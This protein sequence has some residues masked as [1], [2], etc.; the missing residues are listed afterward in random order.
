MAFK[1]YIDSFLTD[2]PVNDTDLKTLIKR[3]TDIGNVLISQEVEIVYNGDNDLQPG[4]ISGYSYLKNIY[5]NNICQEISFKIVDQVSQ[6]ETIELYI[7]TIKVPNIS[8]DLQR[9]LL[10]TKIQDNSY[11]AYINNNRTVK[12]NLASVKTKS[13]E[14]LTAIQPYRMEMFSTFGCV[15]YGPS[16]G[17]T[18]FKGYKVLD[19]FDFIIRTI[20]DNRIT[21]T[22]DYF[23]EIENQ[24]FMLKG[25]ALINPYTQ[26]PLAPEPVIEVSFEELFN[27]MS[28]QYNL[29]FWI[30]DSDKNDIK[31]KIENS[32]RSFSTTVVHQMN[33]LFDL[34]SSIFA[35]QTYGVVKVGSKIFDLTPSNQHI[36]ETT[37]FG[38]KEESYFPNGQCNVA[39]ELNLVN[40]FVIDSNII[41]NLI[42]GSTSEIDSICLIECEQVD[43]VLF[44]TRA[45]IFYPFNNS[46]CCYN[47]GLNNFNKLQRNSGRFSDLLSNLL[48]TGSNTYLVNMGYDSS[49]NR[50]YHGGGSA[51][52]PGFIPIGGQTYDAD[53]ENETT[54]GGYDFD[55]NY[56][57]V[58]TFEYTAPF[59][60]N[61]SFFHRMFFSIAGIQSF[62]NF[63]VSVGFQHLDVGSVFI[64]QQLGGGTYG[65]NGS[66]SQ[67]TTYVV[68]ALAGEKIRG[69]YRFVYNPNGTGNQQIARNLV[70]GYTSFHVCTGVPDEGLVIGGSDMLSNKF[71]YDFFHDI[72]QTDFQAIK[73]NPTG[74]ITFE[75][76]GVTRVGW[77]ESMNRNDWTGQTQIRLITYQDAIIRQ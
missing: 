39:T 22:S 35:D 55:G 74:A 10:K 38:W 36:P 68:A 1:F 72:N 62:E 75:K 9:T 5:D 64:A 63:E 25:Q 40:E 49:D 60:G 13:G 31:L 57:N 16:N 46:L 58:T 7:G 33:D 51:S 44:T 37:G 11:Y 24:P 30:D 15:H 26:F 14:D 18:Y 52:A 66:F 12:V 19:V 69:I 20:T 73:A 17:G 2:Q 23:T 71:F 29:V 8:I 3:N 42:Q 32:D 45:T 65:F 41:V 54:N 27:E 6:S 67:D 56:D 76:D 21:V 53:Y 48:A 43:D 28:K 61:Y 34:T 47:L 50:V 4:E 59:D 77:I 70:V